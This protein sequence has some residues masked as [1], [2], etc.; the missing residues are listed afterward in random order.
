M[1]AL[2][3]FNHLPYEEALARISACVAL[4]A[5]AD[6][7]VR[8]R[9]Y[10]SQQALFSAAQALAQKWDEAAL[11]QALSAHPRI[12]ETHRERG[13]RPRCRARSRGRLSSI[14]P[15]PCG[16]EMPAT[17]PASDASF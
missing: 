14:M 13:R 1:I 10:S 17:K 4:P 11:A 12:G 16:T 3:D 5:W 7:L 9:P 8:G 2:Q 6:A 15:T